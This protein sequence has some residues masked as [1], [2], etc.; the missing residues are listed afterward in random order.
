M[1]IKKKLLDTAR[2]KIRFNHYSYQEKNLTTIEY[3]LNEE[4]EKSKRNNT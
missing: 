3:Y 1:Q 2:G 4:Q